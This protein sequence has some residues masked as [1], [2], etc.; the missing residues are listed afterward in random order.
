MNSLL[1]LTPNDFDAKMHHKILNTSIVLFYATTCQHS[2]HLLPIFKRL[3]K[4]INGACQVGL[5]NVGFYN[6]IIP[7]SQTTDTP[8]TY[9][10][11]IVLYNNGVPL[12]QYE[13]EQEEAAIVEFIKS[14]MDKLKQ[15]TKKIKR[16]Y[17]EGNP[18]C[19]DDEECYLVVAEQSN[20][21]F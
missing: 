12:I 8:I 15:E 1:Y 3:P 7:R 17:C 6:E 14:M 4:T 10:P 9:V 11:Y 2:L 21:N 13:G 19:G 20:N 18:L 5:F 16:A